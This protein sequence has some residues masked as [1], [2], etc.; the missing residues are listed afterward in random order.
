MFENHPLVEREANR[1]AV[2]RLQLCFAS[3]SAQEKYH[4]LYI[5]NVQATASRIHTNGALIVQW[6]MSIA[7]RLGKEPRGIAVP[8]AIYFPGS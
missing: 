1:I 5:A 6:A 4:V 2:V 7:N 3:Y 8:Y